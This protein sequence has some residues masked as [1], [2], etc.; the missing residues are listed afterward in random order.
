MRR[1]QHRIIAGTTVGVPVS[2]I[3]PNRTLLSLTRRAT[4]TAGVEFTRALS[5][6]TN[7]TYSNWRFMVGLTISATQ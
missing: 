3:V 7:Y 5:N 1:H 4:L 6:V 2:V